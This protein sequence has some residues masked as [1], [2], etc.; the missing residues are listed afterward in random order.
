MSENLDGSKLD[1]LMD[2]ILVR[3][4]IATVHT[5]VTFETIDAQLGRA[6]TDSIVKGEDATM[7]LFE[8]PIMLME[9]TF[10]LVLTATVTVVEVFKPK[11]FVKLSVIVYDAAVRF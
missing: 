3:G 11:K 1:D 10:G 8:D 9:G 2:V 4:P 7:V 5:N 6:A